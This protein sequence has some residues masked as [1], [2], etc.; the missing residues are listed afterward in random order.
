MFWHQTYQQRAHTT[1]T[2][3]TANIQFCYRQLDRQLILSLCGW[4]WWCWCT[5]HIHRRLARAINTHFLLWL[6]IPFSPLDWVVWWIAKILTFCLFLVHRY[7]FLKNLLFS[8][9]YLFCHLLYNFGWL[10]ES[11]LVAFLTAF[12]ACLAVALRDCVFAS[13]THHHRWHPVSNDIS[14]HP[15]SAQGAKLELI[16]PLDTPAP[17]TYNIFFKLVHWPVTGQ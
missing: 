8:A 2:Q 16:Q 7:K 1:S 4:I 3:G 5:W 17:V 13:N 6:A 10:A 11:F 14:I 15:P 9:C 12:A